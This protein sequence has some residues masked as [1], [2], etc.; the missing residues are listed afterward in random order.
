VAEEGEGQSEPPKLKLFEFK[1]LNDFEA[2]EPTAEVATSRTLD[3]LMDF[4]GTEQTV[5]DEGGLKETVVFYH[6]EETL[7]VMKTV[8]DTDYLSFGYW[9]QAR[10]PEDSEGAAYAVNVF[11]DG[12][13]PYGGTN[14]EDIAEALTKVTDTSATYAGPATGVFV[15]KANAAPFNSG[16]FT[17]SAKLTAT[18]GETRSIEGHVSDFTDPETEAG[19]TGWRLPLQTAF[20]ENEEVL[21]DGKFRGATEG[22]GLWTGQFFGPTK[23]TDGKPVAPSGVAGEF[24]GSFGAG[25]VKQHVLGAF[26][27]EKTP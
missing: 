17:A 19:Y 10:Q 21:S 7:E 11:A 1:A 6:N 13:M 20:F 26:G 5:E 2:L 25:D 12:V 15:Q 18:F 4:M 8:R 27:A 16:R 24:S 9:T 14:S 23:G 22:P 3:P